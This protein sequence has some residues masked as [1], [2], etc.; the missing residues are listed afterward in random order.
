M[1]DVLDSPLLHRQYASMTARSSSGISNRT[2]DFPF[3]IFSSIKKPRSDGRAVWGGW[4]G[5]SCGG[6]F[7]GFALKKSQKC[8]PVFRR[9]IH[10][11]PCPKATNGRLAHPG[12]VG[13]FGVCHAGNLADFDDQLLW[14]FVW[15]GHG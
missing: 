13:D 15:I 1:T 9:C 5:R 10:E 7:F 14:R 2:S 4:G 6:R 3:A 8:P 11:S 12:F